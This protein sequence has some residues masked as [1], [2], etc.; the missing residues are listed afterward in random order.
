MAL[1]VCLSPW[2]DLRAPRPILGTI[3]IHVVNGFIS[4]YRAFEDEECCIYILTGLS[5]LLVINCVVV[6]A[7]GLI[8]VNILVYCLLRSAYC[9]Y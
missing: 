7:E 3:L 6:S 8:N 9:S 1:C 5:S 4:L 2:S